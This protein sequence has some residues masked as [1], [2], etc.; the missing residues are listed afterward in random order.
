MKFESILSLTKNTLYKTLLSNKINQITQNIS[1]IKK[2]IFEELINNNLKECLIKLKSQ[3]PS[4]LHLA[5]FIYRYLDLIETPHNTLNWNLIDPIQKNSIPHINQLPYNKKNLSKVAILKLN[6][7]LGTTMGCHST[8]SLIQLKTKKNFIDITIQQLNNFNQ[9][10]NCDLPLILLNSFKTSA[11]T[12][13]FIKKYNNLSIYN[14]CQS[15]YPRI[16]KHNLKPFDSWLNID[17]NWYPPGHGDIYLTLKESPILTALL[18]KGIEYLF[19]SNSDN[20]GATLSPEILNFMIQHNHDFIMEVTP[21]SHLDIKGGCLTKYKNKFFLLERSQVPNNKI[22]EFE[23]ISKFSLF[24]TNN[25]WVN[26]N[27]L[28]NS[29]TNP[30]FNLSTI[31]NHKKIH[32][33]SIIQL[34][35]AMG[36]AI[37]SFDNPTAIIVDRSRFFPVKSISD[38]LII[39]S[40]LIDINKKGI[41]SKTVSTQLPIVNLINQCSSMSKFNLFFKKIPS[42]KQCQKLTIIG[43][44]SFGPNVTI[45]GNVSIK[46]KKPFYIENKTLENCDILINQNKLKITQKKTPK[47]SDQ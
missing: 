32:N 3:N 46:T 35:T 39:K 10:Y 30:T 45:I 16:N 21:K 24:N 1:P 9:Q 7:G 33:Q 13:E 37:S 23:N 43:P 25:L 40:D 26:I 44:V 36:S 34:E 15:K 6:G 22:P 4:Q 38:L 18:K 12:N 11:D 28:L 47:S 29:Q 8:K 19:I 17:D 5:H 41:V 31:I 42:L 20:L 2:T 14:L 27:A